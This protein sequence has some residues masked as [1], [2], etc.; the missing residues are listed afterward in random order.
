MPRTDFRDGPSARALAHLS[1]IVLSCVLASTLT[2]GCGGAA[3]PREHGNGDAGIGETDASLGELHVGLA[4]GAQCSI[5]SQCSGYDNRKCITGMYPLATLSADPGLQAIGVPLP[6]GYCSSTPSCSS[7][8][9]CGTG[10]RCFQ[11]LIDVTE[12]TLDTIASTLPDVDVHSFAT[13]GACLDPCTDNTECREGYVCA[14]PIAS[15]LGLVP[16]A[17]LETYCVGHDDE[18]GCGHC[19]PNSTCTASAAPATCACDA[20]YVPDGNACVPGSSPCNPSPCMNGGTCSDASGTASCSCPMGFT[21]ALCETAIVD[22][23]ASAP[24]VHGTCMTGVGSA[25]SCSCASGYTGANCDALVDCGALGA[26]ANG[27]VTTS[28][29]TTVGNAAAYGCANGFTLTGNA[30]RTCGASGAWSGS[31]PTCAPVDCGSLASPT[32]GTVTTPNGTAS[33]ATATY[34]CSN[35]FVPSAG[36][37]RT[38]QANGQWSGAAPTCVDD[39]CAPNPCGNGGTCVGASGGASYTC[40]CAGGWSGATCQYPL[41]SCIPDPCNGHGTCSGTGTCACTTGYSGSTCNAVADC[42]ALSAPANGSVTTASGTTAG[43]TA[44]YACNTGYALNGGGSRTCG[45][46]GQWSGSA[47]GCT[48]LDC[49]AL[50]GPAHG[51]VATPSGTEVGSM[52]TYACAEGYALVGSTSRACQTNGQWSGSAPSCGAA[53]CGPLASPDHGSVTTTGGT[54]L[55]A[56]ATYACD[57]G[58]SLVGS[59]SRSCQSDGTWDGSA[60]TCGTATAT[61]CT[62]VY[63]FANPS[64]TGSRFR[65]QPSAGATTV[66][67]GPGEIIL[68]V[69]RDASGKPAAGAVELLYYDMDQFFGPVSGVTTETRVCLLAPGTAAPSVSI[70]STPPEQSAQPGCI[71]ETNTTAMA[72]G[73]FAIS[74]PGVGTMSFGCYSPY[75]TSPNYTPAQAT[76]TAPGCMQTWFSY[77]RIRCA[78]GQACAFAV[79]PQDTWIDKSASW[80]QHF[81]APIALASNFASLTMGDPN[82]GATTSAWA[83]VPNNDNGWTGFALVGTLDAAASTCTP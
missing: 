76:G 51:A 72:T 54:T 2:Q 35:G 58:Y 62:L 16:G 66:D 42:G 59:A 11:P 7:D 71:A 68:R 21:G 40:A 41:F 24:C 17:R 47:P 53:D 57:S 60:P 73:T 25:Y 79:S 8:A 18:S 13:Y 1:S 14:T 61:T 9:Q 70:A 37:S 12:E 29:A 45:T 36:T 69:P 67:V 81:L 46:N 56:T 52:A 75:P 22:G 3:P 33:A 82:G 77:G 64:P 43:K 19:G 27:S 4:V 32:N 38:C 26:P 78:S 74:A 6:N 65:I 49:G 63:R 30:T 28:G 10:G 31:A 15:L 55:G 23:C 20:G 50:A 48:P 80:S 5:D 39:P 83:H 34:A 44:T